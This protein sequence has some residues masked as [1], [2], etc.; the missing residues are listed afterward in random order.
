M[1]LLR[2]KKS[3]SKVLSGRFCLR[4]LGAE[5]QLLTFE[6][7]ICKNCDAVCLASEQRIS[8]ELGSS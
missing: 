7:Y 2:N 6:S 8:F 4:D 5:V 3:K 1:C